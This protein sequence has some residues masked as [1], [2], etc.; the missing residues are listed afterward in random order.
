MK[1]LGGHNNVRI[2][3]EGLRDAQNV[4]IE[5]RDD[6]TDIVNEDTGEVLYSAPSYPRALENA[7]AFARRRSLRVLRVLIPER[8]ADAFE[9]DGTLD[10]NERRAIRPEEFIS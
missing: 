9:C 3:V 6:E 4:Y 2:S 10:L 7:I 1:K 8:K 5:W